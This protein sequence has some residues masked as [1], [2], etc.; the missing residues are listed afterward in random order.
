MIALPRDILYRINRDFAA[1]HAQTV[2]DLL[3]CYNGPERDRVLRC[4]LHLADGSL[5]RLEASLKTAY[6]DYRDI[7]YFAEY[8]THD[9]RLHDFTEP[10]QKD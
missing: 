9:Q 8:D 2:I 4:V 6:M 3:S 5:E 1:D 10:F 7:I